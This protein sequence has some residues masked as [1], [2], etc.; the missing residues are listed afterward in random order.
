M[1]DP[2]FWI[3]QEDNDPSHCTKG[4]D[5]VAENLRQMSWI[6]V[7]IHPG[8][9]PDPNPI[10]GILLVLK[11][12]AK[13]HVLYPEKGEEKWDG[14]QKYLKSVLQEVRDGITSERYQKGAVSLHQMVVRRC[15]LK[16]GNNTKKS[17]CTVVFYSS[18]VSCT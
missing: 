12:C 5:N 11:Q 6:A 8:Q 1:K 17:T 16:S 10:E 7:I 4:Q 13:R 15:A 3:L 9:S 2:C 18:I 14:S